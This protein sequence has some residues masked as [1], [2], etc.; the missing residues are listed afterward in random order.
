MALKCH[1]SCPSEIGNDTNLAAAQQPF[2]FSPSHWINDLFLFE[3]GARASK[4]T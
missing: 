3:Q 4:D 2:H 1:V